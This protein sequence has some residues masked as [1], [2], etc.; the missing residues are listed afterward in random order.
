MIVICN[1]DEY[2]HLTHKCDGRCQ[3][4]E[5]CI[6]ADESENISCPIDSI[7]EL[8]IVVVTEKQ[9]KGLEVV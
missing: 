5:W 8:G 9:Y 2:K 4:G 6:F 7:D 3:A 1:R